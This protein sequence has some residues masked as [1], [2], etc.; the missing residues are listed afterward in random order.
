MYHC[1]SAKRLPA[2]CPSIDT[3][4]LTINTLVTGAFDPTPTPN[5][6]PI[7]IANGFDGSSRVSRFKSTF[8]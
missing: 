5:P 7:P 1:L 4:L 6:I 8:C 3:A 2:V